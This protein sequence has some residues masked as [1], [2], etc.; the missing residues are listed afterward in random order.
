[1]WTSICSLYQLHQKRMRLSSLSSSSSSPEMQRQH[2]FLVWH[3]SKVVV[4]ENTF[5][6]SPRTLQDVVTM[7]FHL[8]VLAF[9]PHTHT[10]ASTPFSSLQIDASHPLDSLHVIHGPFWTNS[11]QLTACQHWLIDWLE[12]NGTFSTVRLY[13]AFRSY[14]LC[15]GKLKHPGSLVHLLFSS[16]W[17]AT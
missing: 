17:P 8:A 16:G 13:R 7:L 12:F 10:R 14:S 6:S 9:Q 11:M 2:L 5:D 1:M 3:H 4:C 15:F